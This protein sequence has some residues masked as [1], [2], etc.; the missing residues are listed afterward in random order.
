MVKKWWM[1]S[2]GYQIYPKSFFDSNNDGIGDINGITKKLE[3]L[4]HLGVNLIWI[5]PFYAS[6]MDDNGYDVKDFYD[7]DPQ[8][9]TIDDVKTLIQEAHALNIKVIFDYV[10]NHTSDEHEWFIESRKNKTNP[11][12]DYYIWHDGKMKNNQRVEPTNWG[13]FFGGSAWCYDEQSDSY[14]MKIFSNK[15]PDLN[16]KN[17]NVRQAMIDVGQYWLDMGADGFRI[18]AVS[19]LDRAPFEDVLDQSHQYPLDWH[20]FSNLPKVHTYLKELNQKLFQPNEALTIGEVGGEAT[21]DNA[22]AYAGFDSHELSMVFNFD[23]NW[24]N[25]L[26]DITNPKK[27][28]VDVVRLKQ[29]FKKWQD[30]FDGK[31]WLP[32]NWLNHDQ[33]RLVSHYGHHRYPKASAKM[34]ASVIHFMKGTPFIYQGEEIGMTNYPFEDVSDFDDQS[35]VANYYYQLEHE[36]D[37]PVFALKKASLRSRD[38]ARTPMQWDDSYQAGFTAVNPWFPVNPNYR[39]INVE[40]NIKDDDSIYHYYRQLIAL[41]RTSKYHDVITYGTLTFLD[42]DDP[43]HFCYL[44]QNDQYTL[45]LIHSFSA[46]RTTYDLSSYHI[47]HILIKNYKK[48]TIKNNQIILKPFE[49][50]VLEV[51]VMK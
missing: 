20:K 47:Q 21:I 50:V 25:N 10:L 13:S 36:T 22:L 17:P 18:D 3:Y 14:Y 7:V 40:R 44:R 45:L 11:Y 35:S 34:L 15:M 5:G 38:N 30:A 27:I 48:T 43:N 9:G 28:K 32:L 1:E 29:V 16:W 23:H 6:P 51:K 46:H 4:H 26:S 41:R 42:L 49:S 2:V 12:R 24:C 33:P 31:G 19:H 39:K 8:F 37:N